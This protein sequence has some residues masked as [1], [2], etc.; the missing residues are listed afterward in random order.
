MISASYR[1]LSML[2]L[3][4]IM[5]HWVRKLDSL[6]KLRLYLSSPPQTRIRDAWKSYV[7]P[8][9]WPVYGASQ[10]I[11]KCRTRTGSQVRDA[12]VHLLS[13]DVVCALLVPVQ[14]MHAGDVHLSYV[15]CSLRLPRCSTRLPRHHPNVPALDVRVCSGILLGLHDCHHHRIR[16]HRKEL[17]CF[18]PMAAMFVASVFTPCSFSPLSLALHPMQIPQTTFE[19]MIATLCML[20]GASIFAYVVSSIVAIVASFG[21]ERRQCVAPHCRHCCY[22]R[23]LISLS[24][25]AC[26]KCMP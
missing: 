17:L 25:L 20:A 22:T 15:V 7:S 13:R 9:R 12:A 3:V 6:L 24:L 19:R 16:G 1:V 21:E 10:W 2:A 4:L 26:L 18:L 8:C 11:L 23:D 14:C 5:T